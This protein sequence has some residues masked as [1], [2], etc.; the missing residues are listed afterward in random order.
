MHAEV[1]DTIILDSVDVGQPTRQGSILEVRSDANHE[2]YRVRWDNG[3]E[4]LFYPGTT[5]RIIHQ[6]NSSR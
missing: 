2:H 6:T 5:A 4:S 3:Q 1:G